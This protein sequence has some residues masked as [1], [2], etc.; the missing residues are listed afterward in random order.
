VSFF[1]VDGARNKIYCQNLCLLAK[2]FLDHKTLY[3]DVEPFL[4]Y[5]LTECD[6]RGCHMVGYFS[7][8]KDSPDGYNLA[9]VTGDAAVQLADGTSRRLDELV[10]ASQRG[11]ELTLASPTPDAP[12]TAPSSSSSSSSSSPLQ[13]LVR[14]D[15]AACDAGLV[16]GEKQCV[17][18]T[19]QD[20]RT[21][22]C[23]PDHH[24][25]TSDGEW[26]AASQVAL[27]T[28]RLA[29]SSIEAPLDAI[30]A[31]E[32]HFTV[33]VGDR[34]PLTMHDDTSRSR[35][36]AFARLLGYTLGSPAGQPRFGN[37]LDRNNASADLAR[38]QQRCS[39]GCATL[40]CSSSSSPVVCTPST[41]ASQT[42]PSTTSVPASSSSTAL[43]FSAE[44][45]ADVTALEG[46]RLDDGDSAASLPHFLHKAPVAVVREFLG[47]LFGARGSAPSLHAQSHSRLTPVSL[48]QLC[49]VADQAQLASAR[50][51]LDAVALLLQRCGVKAELSVAR[52][53]ANTTSC[54]SSS[55]SSTSSCS[56]ATDQ[57]STAVVV[58]VLTLPDSLS[59]AERVGFRLCS[60]KQQR[61]AA[62][63][64]Y[65]RLGRQ[66][67]RQVRWLSRQVHKV[68]QAHIGED[69]GAFDFACVL[70]S[71]VEQ[72]ECTEGVCH[73][74]A[75]QSLK[76]RWQQQPECADDWPSLV[77]HPRHL[78]G[79]VGAG[80][81]FHASDSV[82]PA[83]AAH[84]PMLSLCVIARRAVGTRAVYDLSVPGN[85]SFVANG[86][87][88][89]NCILTLPPYQRKG[90][91]K[92][93]IQFSYELSKIE[94]K[95]G[96]PER[97][98]SRCLV[99]SLVKSFTLSLSLDLLCS[100]PR[101]P[102]TLGVRFVCC[103][104]CV[105]VCVCV[106]LIFWCVRVFR[107]ATLLLF[108]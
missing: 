91:G 99:I 22:V 43:C 1:E 36:L 101:C 89:H 18:L 29:V 86:V 96:T 14:Y 102:R 4:F 58:A 39:P 38:L 71:A 33:R 8:E 84:L 90:Y 5:V 66:V 34:A 3:Y 85:A 97:P 47:G 92:L 11:M 48:T 49:G 21:L 68:R 35:M 40:E 30:T 82:V 83:S 69:E 50:Q 25:L 10:A 94:Q 20:G 103:L 65:W 98:L 77:P 17:E 81:W 52:S 26:V 61:L 104:V 45:M 57:Q 72:L 55:T 59:F 62:S 87:S 53:S 42:P 108:R 73:P 27:R 54:T 95:V 100:L 15:T 51:H 37:Q 23:T 106:S 80:S 31:D 64:V 2:L 60:Q 7:K 63:C 41:S 46:V 32:R 6:A 56:N 67:S 70:T 19:L 74:L 13:Q 107:C 88:V 44:W 12:P 93:L 76:R 75:V 24:L 78:L 79:E 9:C 16:R 105:C 28:T